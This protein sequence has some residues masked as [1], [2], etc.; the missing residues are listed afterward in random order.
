M[1]KDLVGEYP[2]WPASRDGR[3]LTPSGPASAWGTGL[4]G[5]PA[6]IAYRS[7]GIPIEARHSVPARPLIPQLHFPKSAKWI[8]GIELRDDDAPEV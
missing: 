3:T 5:D 2:Y 1:A 8:R 6:I 7:D 4:R